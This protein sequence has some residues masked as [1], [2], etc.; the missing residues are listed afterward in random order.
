M[1]QVP[2]TLYGK[3]FADYIS[4]KKECIALK[5]DNYYN[6]LIGGVNCNL[7][8]LSKLTII[9]Y[10]L[11]KYN[12]VTGEALDC[13]YNKKPFLGVNDDNYTTEN[14]INSL[15]HLEVFTKYLNKMCK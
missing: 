3:P 10:L 1:G 11:S 5:G 8:E 15:T 14:Q 9:D 13:I 7:I 12:P 2:T 4:S 6:K